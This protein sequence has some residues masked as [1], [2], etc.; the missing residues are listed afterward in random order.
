MIKSYN[1][2]C[3]CGA[4]AKFSVD[5]STFNQS[6]VDELLRNVKAD[7]DNWQEDHKN[8]RDLNTRAC[9]CGKK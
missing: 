9:K 2:E 1:L 8:C 7:A 4:K 3:G 5:F 6:R